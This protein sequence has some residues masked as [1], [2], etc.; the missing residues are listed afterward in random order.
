MKMVMGI[1]RTTCLERIVENLA[2]MEIRDVTITKVKGIGEQIT[3]YKAYAIH[4]V[5]LVIVAD[6][7]VDQVTNLIIE[8]ARTSSAGDGIVTVCPVDYMIKIR[9]LKRME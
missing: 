9:T 1:V 8:A 4:N 6:E 7:K 2:A 3:L 5:V